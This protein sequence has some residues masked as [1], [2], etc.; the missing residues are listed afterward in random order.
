VNQNLNQHLN[1]SQ[2]KIKNEPFI[3]NLFCGKYIFDYLN[4]PEYDSNTELNQLNKSYI[5]PARDYFQKQTHDKMV[6]SNGEFTADAINKFNSLSLYSSSFPK[7]YGGYELDSTILTRVIE[8]M[9]VFPSLAVNYIYSNEIAAKCILLFGS[10]EQKSKYLNRISSGEAK[11][12][13][14]YSEPDN[15]SDPAR[16]NVIA[17]VDKS[18]KNSEIDYV[19]N[20][21]KSWIASLSNDPEKNDLVFIVICKTLESDKKECVNAFLIEKSTE[22]LEMSKIVSNNDGL[23]LYEVNLNNV[24]VSKRNLLGLPGMGF[25]I[26]NKVLENSRFL[27]GAIC[28]GLLKDLLKETTSFCVNSKRFGKSLSEFPIVK[29]KIAQIETAIYAMESMTYFTAGIVDSYEIPDVGSES[30]LTKI[31]CTEQLKV[32]IISSSKKK[33][34]KNL[35]YSCLVMH[36]QLLRNLW[37]RSIQKFGPVQKKNFTRHQFFIYN[38]KH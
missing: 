38:A 22:G 18:S 6:S 3:K 28:V 12:C 13:Y 30:A 32:C 29:E 21:K 15:G 33:N 5:E 8:E 26:G 31:F 36:R 4:Y 20:G 23:N 24:K 1:T 34:S 14:C 2:K 25:E 7:N 17:T 10:S 37:Y 16:F 27:V 9:G 11:A 19:L 35:F